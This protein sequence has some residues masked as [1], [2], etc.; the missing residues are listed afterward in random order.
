MVDVEYDSTNVLGPTVERLD[1][2][3][4]A[5]KA[6]GRWLKKQW[7][8]AQA[9]QQSAQVEVSRL[10]KELHITKYA[11]QSE[12]EIQDKLQDDLAKK[13]HQFM[14]SDIRASGLAKDYKKTKELL[15]R[16]E[17]VVD[18]F[19][20]ELIDVRLKHRDAEETMSK[21]DDIV[22]GLKKEHT[23]LKNVAKQA[24]QDEKNALINEEK[25]RKSEKE[26]KAACNEMSRQHQQMM[27]SHENMNKEKLDM[28]AYAKRMSQQFEETLKKYNSEKKE[29]ERLDAELKAKTKEW[30]EQR[31]L[32]R[33]TK[34][35]LDLE[36]NRTLGLRKD[37]SDA[38]NIA[39]GC[40]RETTDMQHDMV[41]KEDVVQN[42]QKLVDDRMADIKELR[43]KLKEA[44][45]N[46][47]HL[48]R[49]LRDTKQRDKISR[50]EAEEAK[51]DFRRSMEETKSHRKEAQNEKTLTLATAREAR[52]FRQQL[53]KSEVAEKQCLEVIDKQSAELAREIATKKER[54]REIKVLK[55][56]IEDWKKKFKDMK[57]ESKSFQDTLKA[58]EEVV[59]MTRRQQKDSASAATKLTVDISG[60][61]QK[62]QHEV[63]EKQRVELS[64]ESY[65]QELVLM[66]DKLKQEKE[67]VAQQEEDKKELNRKIVKLH[68]TIAEKN[69]EITTLTEA[70]AHAN[71]AYRTAQA[72]AGEVTRELSAEKKRC[73]VAVEE[74]PPIVAS[75]TSAQ[76]QNEVLR[77]KIEVHEAEIVTLKEQKEVNLERA[78][79]AEKEIVGHVKRIKDLEESREK[80]AQHDQAAGAMKDKMATRLFE[81]QAQ[82]PPLI[83]ERDSYKDHLERVLG[84]LHEAR[85]KVP[86]LVEANAKVAE[87]LAAARKDIEYWKEQSQSFELAIPSLTDRLGHAQ[88]ALREEQSMK[89]AMV[90]ELHSNRKITADAQQ[91]AAELTGHVQRLIDQ[92]KAEGK[93]PIGEPKSPKS[94]KSKKKDAFQVGAGKDRKN[95][96]S[97][98][99]EGASSMKSALGEMSKSESLPAIPGSRGATPGS[100]GTMLTSAGSGASNMR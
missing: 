3:L 52:Q 16:E 43:E 55:A 83:E 76:N 7:R 64:L 90:K 42:L 10:A 26:Q 50:A 59:V 38:E 86:P 68:G 48:S 29:R 24:E 95:L 62:V 2:E 66:H 72:E 100:R 65:R 18:Q 74:V 31:N 30:L 69:Q 12:Q 99:S 27:K 61:R 85:D 19:T 20:E 35:D 79:K 9:D 63:Q 75:V 44:E 34:H 89:Q 58:T 77:A 81:A 5:E 71:R 15:D 97:A 8:Q 67:V 1:K 47:K 36:L 57:A 33:T 80:I 25:V 13:Q 14:T 6:Q 84:E 54:E 82:V 4:R 60:V 41:K 37:K 96:G 45:D 28:E 98:G 49:D 56:E 17:S 32:A 39:R 11:L 88:S 92:L 21:H 93:R 22:A 53:E 94:P 51:A 78:L 70:V 40:K 46:V 23:R 87:E 91:E 73:K